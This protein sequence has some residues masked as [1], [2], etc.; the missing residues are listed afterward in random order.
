MLTGGLIVLGILVALFGIASFTQQRKSLVALFFFLTTIG[1]A[2]WSIGIAVFMRAQ[3]PDLMLASAAVYY[4]AAALIALSALLTGYTLRY[5]KAPPDK[6]F[7]VMFLPFLVVALTVLIYPQSLVSD[8][9]VAEQNTASLNNHSYAAYALYFLVYYIGGL[10]LLFQT[11]RR[12]SGRKR[13]SYAFLFLAYLLSGLVGVW[14]NLILPWVGE[15]GYIW[16]GPLSVLPFL[17]LAYMAIVRYELL[18]VRLA[19]SRTSAYVL[20]LGTLVAIYVLVTN[21]VAAKVASFGENF[22]S[23]LHVITTLLLVLAFQPLKSFFDRLTNS[24]FYRKQ[25]Q[26][27]DF[28]AKVNQ[29]LTGDSD[30]NSLLKRVSE[31][32]AKTLGSEQVFFAVYRPERMMNIGTKGHTGVVRA[33][34]KRLAQEFESSWH[35]SAVMAKVFLEEDDDLQKV[36]ETYRAEIFVGLKQSGV[37]QGVLVLGK[38]KARKYTAHDYVALESIADELAIA[39]QNAKSIQEVHKL[40]ETLQQRID[41]ATSELRRSNQQLRRLDEAKDEFMSMA[42]HQLR[43]PLTS[44][45]GYI[46]MILEGDAGEVTPMQRKFLTEAFMSSERMVHLINDFLNV[47]RLQTG[48]FAIEKHP[49][50]LV[51]IVHQ[52]IEG[53]SVNAKIRNLSFELDISSNIPAKL[54]LDEA[55]M[56]QVIMNFA[57]NAIYYSHEGSVI[58]VRLAKSAG[59]IVFTIKD[60]GI[61]VPKA[62]QAAL[63]TK[64]FRAK[65]ARKHRPDGTGVGIYLAKRVVRGHGGEIVFSSVEGKGSTFGFRL[66]PEKLKVTK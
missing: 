21:F 36:F 28:Y 16:A 54:M 66:S 49:T 18:D 7:A 60:S 51:K 33:D 42:S 59:D 37:V 17:A 14:F 63:F 5:K 52:E 20:L 44:I 61:G 24:I 50:D 13:P 47:S 6:L 8:V 9:V 2:L 23:V 27:S 65:N 19:F 4:S 10:V 46:D 22:G 15:Y 3:T 30:L 35:S 31:L 48:K 56:R 1:A 39:L 38:S 62:E 25:Y 26:H 29:I 41:E 55:K 32:L 53:L 57:D 34:F 40:N 64:F 43:T 11:Y 45:K 12:S 58:K